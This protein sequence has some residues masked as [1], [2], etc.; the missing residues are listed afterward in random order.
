[1]PYPGF[2]KPQ[3]NCLIRENITLVR[4]NSRAPFLS[5]V[6]KSLTIYYKSDTNFSAIIWRFYR[7]CMQYFKV[8]FNSEKNFKHLKYEK[9]K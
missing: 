8:T 7:C 3:R 6:Y 9:K 5:R 1:M 4:I 2:T